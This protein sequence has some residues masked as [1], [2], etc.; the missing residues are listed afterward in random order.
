MILSPETRIPIDTSVQALALMVFVGVADDLFDLSWKK[1]LFLEACCLIPLMLSLAALLPQVAPT[2][3][4]AIGVA[5]GAWL[6]L[7]SNGTNLMDGIDGYVGT[8]AL[9]TLSGLLFV[10]YQ[11]YASLPLAAVAALSIGPLALFVTYN[12][13]PARVFLGDAGSLSFGFLTGL[14]GMLLLLHQPDVPRLVALLVVMT[15][16][17]V[18]VVTTIVRRIVAGRNVFSS[19]VDHI[20]HRLVSVLDGNVRRASAILSA[21]QVGILLV[22]YTVDGLSAPVAVVGG[23]FVLIAVSAGLVGLNSGLTRRTRIV[24]GLQVS[25]DS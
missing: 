15:L 24:G 23:V 13:S 17:I 19:D 18:E 3:L 1:K 9:L 5:G 25:E 7:I 4:F 16:P 11:S 10:T 22:A 14:L 20:H 6:L 8:W 2:I 21:V 12:R